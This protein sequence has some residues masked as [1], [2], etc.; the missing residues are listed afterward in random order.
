M[1]SSNKE[2]VKRVISET[3]TPEEAREVVNWFS[4]SMEGLQCLSDMLDRD[5][6][7]METEFNNVPP[8]SPLQSDLLFSRITKK[9]RNRRIRRISLG[10][11]AALLPLLLF[12]GF[13]IYLDSQADLFGKTEYAEIYVPKGEDAHIYFQDGT[14]VFLNAD[15]K[16]RYPRKFGL[17]RRTVHLEGEAYFNVSSGKQRAFV[18]RT[19]NAFV[20]VLGTSFNVNAYGTDEEIRVILDKGKVS[21]NTP[22]NSYSMLPGQQ[23]VYNKTNGESVIQNLSKPSNFSLWK[24]NIIYFNDTPLPKVLQILERRF[25]VS[26]DVQDAGVLRYS[27]T[28]TTRQTSIENILYELQKIAPVKFTMGENNILVSLS[29]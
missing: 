29:E 8:I 6:Y 19:G 28:I 16:I 20:E 5:A 21:F 10:V 12:V 18:V 11:A 25:N 22:L 13:G 2:I 24:N 3:A 4:S 7:L 15:T 23:I 1:Q 26:F 9:M 14:E 17:W 27:Y